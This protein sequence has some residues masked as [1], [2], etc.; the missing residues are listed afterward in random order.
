MGLKVLT[1][2]YYDHNTSLVPF[3]DCS[4]IILRETGI[5]FQIQRCL[6]YLVGS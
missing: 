2:N 1:N 6:T 4:M 3:V 5:L